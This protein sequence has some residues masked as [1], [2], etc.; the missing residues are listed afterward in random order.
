MILSSIRYNSHIVC[1]YITGWS[2]VDIDLLSQGEILDRCQTTWLPGS[3]HKLLKWHV[4]LTMS[5]K[6]SLEL[7]RWTLDNAWWGNVVGYS[8]DCRSRKCYQIA[9]IN[10]S[11]GESAYMNLLRSKSACYSDRISP[12]VGW[13]TTIEGKGIPT[14]SKEVR[15]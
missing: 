12:N 1:S 3:R 8:W 2:R 6:G 7:C 10:Y 13:I 9:R 5:G 11:N 15:K 4:Y 14:Q